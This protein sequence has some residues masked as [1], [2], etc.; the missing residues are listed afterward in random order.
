M[1]YQ[2]IKFLSV[3][4]AYFY[5]NFIQTLDGKVAVK[6]KGY[7][8][9]GSKNDHA[10]LMQLRA[11]ADALIHGGNLAKE[12]GKQTLNSLEDTKFKKLRQALN[13][14]ATTPYYI[15]STHLKPLSQ[16][17]VVVGSLQA[18]LKDINKK[19]YQHVLV[20]GGPTLLTTF[21]RKKL[22]QEL[23]ITIAPK[24]FGTKSKLT[25]NLVEGFLFPAKSTIYLKLLSVKQ[26]GN[27]L[28][29]RF[30]VIN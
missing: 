28:F 17:N 4:Q 23:F 26:I 2:T 30:K 13:K 18:V 20:E 14:P 27:E 22:M 9:I 15:V 24:I 1:L 11:H 16:K 7:W 3:K 25:L 5:T 12:F 21:L 8:P 6:R 29:L 19:G 10:V